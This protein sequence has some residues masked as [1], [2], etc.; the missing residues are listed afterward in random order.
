MGDCPPS[1]RLIHLD[2]GLM[3]LGK[4]RQAAY[5][6]RHKKRCNLASQKYYQSHKDMLQERG[7]ERQRC[8]SL[9]IKRAKSL[10]WNYGLS[11]DQYNKMFFEQDGRCLGCGKSQD[12]FQRRLAVDHDH[13]TGKVR[14]LLCTKCNRAVGCSDDNP[15]ILR[16]LANYL[17]KEMT[18][19]A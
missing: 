19:C 16:Q 15:Q 11:L 10:R 2:D 7:R 17:E 5:Y 9:D 14:G 13:K 4:E 8:L 18:I 3:T 6:A 1:R 12:H